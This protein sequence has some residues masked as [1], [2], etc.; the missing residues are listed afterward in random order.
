VGDG[1][2]KG[3]ARQGRKIGKRKPDRHL[4]V[5]R[6]EDVFQEVRRRD[7]LLAKRSLSIRPDEDMCKEKAHLEHLPSGAQMPEPGLDLQCVWS[8]E[9]Y[10]SCRDY[11]GIWFSGGRVTGWDGADDA[12]VLQL[13]IELERT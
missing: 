4:R 12:D 11:S 3:K 5:V 6:D 10:G 7:S 13:M 9:H 1:R 8:K 2:V